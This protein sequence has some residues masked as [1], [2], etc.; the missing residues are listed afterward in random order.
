MRKE[1]GAL[2]KA[3]Q[4]LR[5]GA[6]QT[7]RALRN[8]DDAYSARIGEMY[9][10]ASPSMQAASYMVG[11]AHPSF[12]KAIPTGMEDGLAK[13]ALEYAIPAAN[14]VPKYAL[15][16]VGVTLAGKALVDLTNGFGGQADQPESATLPL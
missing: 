13:T 14:A 8:M 3:G 6:K 2:R 10:G 12:R 5:I 16:A 7:G 4:R 1:K 11:G 9:K 15:P